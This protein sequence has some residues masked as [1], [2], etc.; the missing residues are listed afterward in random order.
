MRSSLVGDPV[1]SIRLPPETLPICTWALC[2]FPPANIKGSFLL[3]KVI[4]NS[5]RVP[6]WALFPFLPTFLENLNL[7][8]LIFHLFQ[9]SVLCRILFT[10]TSPKSLLFLTH[11]YLNIVKTPLDSLLYIVT[12]LHKLHSVF[13]F[14]TILILLTPFK[15]LSYLPLHIKITIIP[16][17]KSR[18]CVQCL[19]HL[20]FCKFLTLFDMFSFKF[21][22]HDF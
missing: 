20:M 2:S 1:N 6:I 15:C 11:I 5:T 7:Y 22:F 12:T 14:L 13:H 16:A 3:Y 8:S 19:P 9:S 18:A 21:S 4:P 17:I 10:Y